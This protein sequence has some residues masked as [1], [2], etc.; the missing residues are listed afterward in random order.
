MKKKIYSY[1][2]PD[3]FG[4]QVNKLLTTNKDVAQDF[5]DL[6]NKEMEEE[7]IDTSEWEVELV[8]MELTEE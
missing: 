4:P 3:D 6:M 1:Q 8:E 2:G 7:G 5:V